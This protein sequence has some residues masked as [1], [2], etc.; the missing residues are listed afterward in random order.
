M[1]AKTSRVRLGDELKYELVQVHRLPTVDLTKSIKSMV[2][3]PA[4]IP[5][6]N[7]LMRQISTP[8]IVCFYATFLAMLI[9]LV[10]PAQVGRWIALTQLVFQIPL[11]FS[12]VLLMRV[13]LLRCLLTTYDFWFFSTVNV[14]SGFVLAIHLRD[15]RICVVFSFMASIQLNICSDANLQTRVYAGG[16]ALGVLVLSILV[17]VIVLDRIP[18]TVDFEIFRYHGRPVTSIDVL[19][20]LLATVF[21]RLV[22]AMYRKHQ[23]LRLQG[24]NPMFMRCESYR[25]TVKLREDQ[26]RDWN[27]QTRKKHNLMHISEKHSWTRQPLRLVNLRQTYYDRDIALPLMLRALPAK[28]VL[29]KPKQRLFYGLGALGYLLTMNVFFF[30]DARLVYIDHSVYLVTSL[31]GCTCTFGFCAMVTCC[32]QWQLLSSLVLSFDFAF[33]SLQLTMAHICMCDLLFWDVRSFAVL[34]NWLYVHLVLTMDAL[35]PAM[36]HRLNC[37]SRWLRIFVMSCFVTA[38]LTSSTRILFVG[39]D[40]L[41]DRA[42]WTMVM[43]GRELT[44][45]MVPFF[46]GRIWTLLIWSCRILWRLFRQ[47]HADALIVVQG[48]VEYYGDAL[49]VRNRKLQLL[50]ALQAASRPSAQIGRSRLATF[51][52]KKKAKVQPTIGPSLSIKI[53]AASAFTSMRK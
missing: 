14:A 48:S 32:Y 25:C 47:E 16:A 4:L 36:K 46:L 49:S 44:F 3:S 18:D 33:L 12:S 50:P 41:Q 37:P 22:R 35:T 51:L 52:G 24:A 13:D 19:A 9:A 1:R 6:I 31:A 11:A 26:S 34:S 30:T 15:L 45:Y 17:P 43:S 21:I 42:I 28:G 40:S 23:A 27:Q 20:N 10:V 5:R 53:R 38:M 8:S 39:T 7:S 2:F 29:S